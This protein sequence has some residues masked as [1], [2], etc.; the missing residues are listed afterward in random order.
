MASTAFLGRLGRGGAETFLAGLGIPSDQAEQ[1][2]ERIARL[3]QHV[4]YAVPG[5]GR[6]SLFPFRFRLPPAW[7]EKWKGLGAAR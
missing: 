3:P 4:F 7:L 5:G 1:H 6:G 2:A